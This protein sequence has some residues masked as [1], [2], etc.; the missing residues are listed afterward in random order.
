MNTDEEVQVRGASAW[1][2]LEADAGGRS[3]SRFEMRLREIESRSDGLNLTPGAIHLAAEIA[4]LEPD[5]DDDQRIA[6]IVLIVVSLA[7]LQEGSTRFPVTGLESRE[8]MARMLEALCGAGIAG[9]MASS[10]DALLGSDAASGVIGRDPNDYKP[11]IYLQPFVYHQRIRAA[12]TALAAGLTALIAGK[13][14]TAI[15][16]EIDPRL[17]RQALSDIAGRAATEGSMRLSDEQRDAVAAAVRSRLTVISGGPGTGKTSIVLAILRVLVRLGM[18]PQEVALTAPTGKAAYRMDECIRAGLAQ[19]KTRDPHDDALAADCPAASTIHRLLGYSPGL[20]RFR[21]HRNNPISAAVVIVDEGSMLDLALMERLVDAIRPGARL[22]VLGDAD[23]LPSVAAGVVFRDLM[24]PAVEIGETKAN[25]LAASRVQLNRSYRVDP[26]DAPGR[27]IPALA[28]LINEGNT[29]AM[30][31]SGSEGRP[32]VVRRASA[33]ELEFSGVE[34]LIDFAGPSAAFLERWYREWV[35]GGAEIRELAA[36]VYTARENGFDH[37]ECDRLRALFDHLAAARVLC[38][39]RVFETGAD[40]IN[41]RLHR[42]AAEDPGVGAGHDRFIIGEPL[43][44]SRNDYQ[45]MLFNGDQGIALR[46][47]SPG[48]E[49]LAMAVFPR[50]DNFVAFRLDALE[51]EIELGC[52]MTVHKAQG[53]EFDSIAVILPAKK[54]HMLTREILYTAVSRARK[55]VVVIGDETIFSLATSCKVERYSGLREQLTALAL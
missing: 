43:I 11:L 18:A 53:S 50:A 49:P 32:L 54:I 36:G 48:G 29:G 27:A 31:A 20:A 42:L 41:Q 35:R 8:P 25:G 12:E 44:V 55:S 46:V 5:L 4:A 38:V 30:Q 14:G 40:R 1:Q 33:V 39:T 9:T 3:P 21:Y 37:P 19:L 26:S 28:R 17:L 16:I 10:I 47:R 13:Q 22:I 52:A 24:P 23:Q 2:R 7:A 15:E 34:H 6:L 45:R 51:D